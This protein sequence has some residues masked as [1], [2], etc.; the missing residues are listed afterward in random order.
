MLF[1]WI[2]IM[3]QMFF[4]TI[5]LFKNRPEPYWG[6]NWTEMRGLADVS[7][8]PCHSHNDYWRDNPLYSALRVGCIGIEADVWLLEDELYVGHNKREITYGRTFSS[9]YINPIVEILESRERLSNSTEY[10][11]FEADSRQTLILVVDIK[12]D[13]PQT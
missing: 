9:L 7:P 11:I 3:W 5:W 1:S 13:G 4:I 10:G 6:G 8:I 12:T 2:L